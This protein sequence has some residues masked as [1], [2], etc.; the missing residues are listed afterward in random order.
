MNL[1]KLY[2]A[3]NW[4][5]RTSNNGVS[6]DGF[7][8]KRIGAW[9][10]AKK[11]TGKP[12]CSECG[13]FFGIDRKAHSFGVDWSRETFELCEW[14]GERVVLDGN[15]ICVSEYRVIAINS[16]IPEK[17]F[18]AC[19][20]KVAHNGDVINPKYGERWIALKGHCRVEG[21]TGGW[22]WAHHRSSQV[23][24]GQSG[25]VFEAY[26]RSSQEVTRQS[27][28]VFWAH[29][30]SKQTVTGQSGGGFWACDRSKQ[31][32]SG[33]SGGMFEAHNR[34]SQEVSGQ[35]EGGK[36]KTYNILGFVWFI[37]LIALY[38]AGCI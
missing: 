4:M 37:T 8:R 33:Q 29:G 11:W 1:D 15:K 10:K 21:Q 30:R 14:R 26:G 5:L 7:K 20:I 25:G 24:S 13:G 18:D 34:S 32:V 6:Y 35:K 19:N 28:G 23:V 31:T 3:G 17:F 16:N 36:M 38:L 2:E 9:N 27:G 12:I 22:F